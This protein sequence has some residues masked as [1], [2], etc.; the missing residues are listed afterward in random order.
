MEA[1]PAVRPH[2]GTALANLKRPLS[3]SLK[4]LLAQRGSSTRVDALLFPVIKVVPHSGAPFKPGFGLSG[5][6]TMT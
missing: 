6:L 3:E 5:T 2:D 1:K 4:Y